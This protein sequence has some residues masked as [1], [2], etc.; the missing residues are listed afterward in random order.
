ME[1]WDLSDLWI[2]SRSVLTIKACA[3]G[4]MLVAIDAASGFKEGVTAI[5][6]FC[7]LIIWEGKPDTMQK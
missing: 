7:N 4:L 1:A 6:E 5:V 2:V 3:Q